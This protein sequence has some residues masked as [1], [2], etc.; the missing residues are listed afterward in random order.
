M[1]KKIKISPM[2]RVALITSLIGVVVASF[3]VLQRSIKQATWERYVQS[4]ICQDSPACRQTRT[5]VILQSNTQSSTIRVPS[6][7]SS[8]KQTDTEYY[9]VVDL[10]DRQSQFYVLTRVSP[11]KDLFD[12]PNIYLPDYSETNFA[13]INFPQGKQIKLELWEDQ[14]TFIFTDSIGQAWS[15]DQSGHIFFITPMPPSVFSQNNSSLEK[16]K[17]NVQFAV[18]TANH[19][20]IALQ[21]AHKDL[22]GSILVV[23]IVVPMLMFVTHHLTKR[24]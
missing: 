16:Q 20:L 2:W 7:F 6:R 21:K 14:V 4:K 9:F 18:P 5:A 17:T 3:F 10:G 1:H 24:R 8:Q 15:W 22:L 19:P 11:Q 12:L 23:I 13:E